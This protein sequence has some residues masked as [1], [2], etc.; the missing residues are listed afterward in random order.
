MLKEIKIKPKSGSEIRL[1]K[2][3]IFSD[4][5][6]Y[7][8][9]N[10]AFCFRCAYFTFSNTKE[11]TEWAG[12]NGCGNCHL[13]KTLGAYDGVMSTA[14]CNMFLS[15]LGTDINQNRVSPSQLPDFLKLEKSENGKFSIVAAA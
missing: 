5:Y 14:V 7:E 9:F 6:D 2:R 11:N 1:E 8:N 3:D 15:H 4:K 13:L 10:H 12:K